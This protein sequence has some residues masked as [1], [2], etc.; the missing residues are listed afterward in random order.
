[1]KRLSHVVL[2]CLATQFITTES[3]TIRKTNRGSTQNYGNSLHAPMNIL[4]EDDIN[5]INY[6]NP[7]GNVYGSTVKIESDQVDTDLDDTN[8]REFDKNYVEDD[9]IDEE[10]FNKI[11]VLN[12]KE[13][14]Q[15]LKK[16]Y[17]E[18]DLEN[19]K[20]IKH[21]KGILSRALHIPPKE[22]NLHDVNV[23]M[24]KWRIMNKNKQ[25][26]NDL[27][28]N[29]KYHKEIQTHIP[30]QTDTIDWEFKHGYDTD[31]E[32]EKNHIISFNYFLDLIS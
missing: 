12:N 22:I 11:N 15:K 29:N 8:E 14:L 7:R 25:N 24:N 16:T 23:L 17:Y 28:S 13:L 20:L 26:M 9:L 27:K 6:F 5:E 1:M 10:D 21:I 19:E 32:N 4:N 18:N 3:I 2:L 30:K 31:N